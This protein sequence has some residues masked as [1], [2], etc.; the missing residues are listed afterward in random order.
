MALRLDRDEAL[1]TE[2]LSF[3]ED[4]RANYCRPFESGKVDFYKLLQEK[5]S[6]RVPGGEYQCYRNG[7]RRRKPIAG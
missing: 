5:M 1:Y 2:V 4:I 6:Q 3:L 7:R